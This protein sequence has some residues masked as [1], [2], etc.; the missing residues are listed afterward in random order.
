[1]GDFSLMLKEDICKFSREKKYLYGLCDFLINKIL[2]RVHRA[3][4]FADFFKIELMKTEFTW[5]AA[6]CLF[7]KI[8]KKCYIS[9]HPSGG[10]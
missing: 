9:I 7:S 4:K 3:H 8:T 2:P 1:M 6:M 10:G 5:S